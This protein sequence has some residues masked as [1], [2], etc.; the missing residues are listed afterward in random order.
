MSLTTALASVA[1]NVSNEVLGTVAKAFDANALGAALRPLLG[2]FEPVATENAATGEG[3]KS[4]EIPES[5]VARTA[6]L[7]TIYRAFETYRRRRASALAR[8][9]GLTSDAVVELVTGNNDFRVSVGRESG[10]TYISL[11]DVN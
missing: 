4:P 3:T 7:D 2:T 1:P 6:L 10:D 5:P 11:V 9:T 8:L